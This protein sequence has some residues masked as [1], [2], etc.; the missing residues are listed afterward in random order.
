VNRRQLF[1]SIFAPAQ[2]A[3]EA[4]WPRQ[5]IHTLDGAK[6]ARVVR[7]LGAHAAIVESY[8]PIQGHEYSLTHKG[9]GWAIQTGDDVRSL[10]R[11]WRDIEH[12]DWRFSTPAEMPA[13]TRY[14][15]GATI[16]R[17]REERDC[18]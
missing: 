3:R 11:L 14:D 9:T 2:A 17:W 4:T 8:R 1:A 15:G 13:K 16:Q 6:Y 7:D 10:A 12:L 5:R 18:A